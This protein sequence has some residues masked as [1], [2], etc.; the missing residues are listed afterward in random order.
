MFATIKKILS[1][2]MERPAFANLFK[3]SL[4]T[5]RVDPIDM[6]SACTTLSP[7]IKKCADVAINTV[8]RGGNMSDVAR[9]VLNVGEVGFDGHTANTKTIIQDLKNTGGP[10]PFL[11]NILEKMQ[12]QKP[13]DIAD[14]GEKAG[15]ISN[16]EDLIKQASNS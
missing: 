10:C 1:F 9:E 16:W 11:A 15:N 5:G 14:F 13:Q 7:S 4:Q 8:Q 2:L 6:F 12:N 3:K